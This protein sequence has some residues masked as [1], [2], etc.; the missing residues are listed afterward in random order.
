MHE[1]ISFVNSVTKHLGDENER[2]PSPFSRC[3]SRSTLFMRYSRVRG[4]L[5]SAVDSRREIPSNE[6]RGW[7]RYI[8]HPAA[9]SHGFYKLSFVMHDSQ[10]FEYGRIVNRLMYLSMRFNFARFKMY[11]YSK[12][13]IIHEVTRYL[14]NIYV[15]QYSSRVMHFETS[16][17]EYL[18][19]IYK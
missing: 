9:V 11:E 5:L 6:F 16:I 2:R 3:R 15:C 1:S 19:L 4:A 12:C 17:K 7:R 8:L 18:F 10:D 14:H 13:R